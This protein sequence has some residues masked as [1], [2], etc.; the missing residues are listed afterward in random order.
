MEQKDKKFIDILPKI[1]NWE[2]IKYAP[3]LN[4]PHCGKS[5]I[6]Q[7]VGEEIP[8]KPNL[9]GWCETGNGYMIVFECP[10]CFEKYCY[11]GNIFNLFDIE[12]FDFFVKVHYLDLVANGE[13]W[14]KKWKEYLNKKD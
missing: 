9:I 8:E 1:T 10:L 13:E 14:E 6:F 7:E 5:G 12:K 11:H 4:C 3:G 2:S